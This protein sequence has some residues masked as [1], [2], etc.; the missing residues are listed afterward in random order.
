MTPFEP[1][2]APHGVS[3]F[4]LLAHDTDL[5]IYT[6]NWHEPTYFLPVGS[7]R[8]GLGPTDDDNWYHR[9][10]DLV[11]QA[12]T[13][14]HISFLNTPSDIDTDEIDLT[15]YDLLRQ[16]AWMMSTD[17][18]PQWHTLFRS[19]GR[20]RPALPNPTWAV[21]MQGMLYAYPKM[22]YW[23]APISNALLVL[24]P[25]V[26][27]AA[28]TLLY[29]DE[30]V[31]QL[32]SPPGSS[33]GVSCGDESGGNSGGGGPN[34]LRFYRDPR[35]AWLASDWQLVR[36]A[37]TRVPTGE[38]QGA[39]KLLCEM[40]TPAKG[41]WVACPSPTDRALMHRPWGSVV[42]RLTVAEQLRCLAAAFEPDLIRS[43]FVDTRYEP[44]LPKWLLNTRRPQPNPAW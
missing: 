3:G 22:A 21:L 18:H 38:G 30:A 19:K 33:V 27:M 28:R 13:R 10:P 20:R 37:P 14:Q 11:R 29:D 12:G 39:G 32:F 17:T 40:V 42:R 9:V 1:T 31:D 4:L 8:H 6:P 43:V 44:A 23:R 36:G 5:K 26:A 7:P 34:V 16:R 15:P 24:S 41:G 35:Q 2:R 25:S